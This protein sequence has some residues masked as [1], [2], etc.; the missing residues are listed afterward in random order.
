[1]RITIRAYEPTGQVTVTMADYGSRGQERIGA[2]SIALEDVESV[3]QV[4]ERALRR[5]NQQTLFDP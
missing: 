2:W 4:V 1:M 5:L 3:V